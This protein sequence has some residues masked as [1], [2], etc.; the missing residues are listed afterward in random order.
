[1]RHIAAPALA[2]ADIKL[3]SRVTD[4]VYQLDD[5]SK[6]KIE[7]EGGQR[8]LFD[9]VVVT[10]PLGWLKRHTDAFNPPL[11][12]RL[13]QAINSIGYGCLEKVLAVP[14]FALPDLYF[15]QLTCAR[16]T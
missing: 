16:C 15:S 3:N 11:P 4:I 6:V 14:P 5:K 7:V 13:T 2:A 9:E 12:T 8:L 10:T 1:M